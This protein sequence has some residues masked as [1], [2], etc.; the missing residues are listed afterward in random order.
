M[1]AWPSIYILILSVTAYPPLLSLDLQVTGAGL[2]SSFFKVIKIVIH[3][4][5]SLG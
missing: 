4:E 3:L 5:V 2:K 1:S